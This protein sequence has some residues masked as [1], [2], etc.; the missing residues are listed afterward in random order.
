[1][2]LLFFEVLGECFSLSS[3][4]YHTSVEPWVDVDMVVGGHGLDR[5]TG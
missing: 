3:D 2:D 1:M 5:G 4:V